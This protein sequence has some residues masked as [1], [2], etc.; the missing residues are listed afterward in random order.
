MQ[1]M[2]LVHVF[3]SN[4]IFTSIFA[5]F[6]RFQPAS[7]DKLLKA[8]RVLDEDGK[9]FL[10]KDQLSKYLMHEGGE[11]F[12]QEEVDETMMVAVATESGKDAEVIYYK[13]LI[14]LMLDPEYEI[15]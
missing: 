2:L 6:A 7:E 10:T 8:F 4:Q 1:T 14:K 12:S 9:S 5:I 15:I 13:N 11:P 3:T